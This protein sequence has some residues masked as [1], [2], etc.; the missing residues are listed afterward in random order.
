[1][2]MGTPYLIAINLSKENSKKKAVPNDMTRLSDIDYKI[3][4]NHPQWSNE[5]IYTKRIILQVLY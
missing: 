1:M 2:F 3:R 4:M 5:C